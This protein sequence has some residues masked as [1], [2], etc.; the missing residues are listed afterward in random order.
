MDSTLLIHRAENEIK[1][2]GMIFTLSEK[3]ALQSETFSINEP[4]TYY[5]AVITHCYYSIFYGAKAFLLTRGMKVSAPEEH[6]K[7]YEAFKTFVDSGELDVALLRIYQE[8]VVQA[9]HLLGIFKQEKD[10]RGKYTYRTLPQANKDP[11]HESIVHATTFFKHM[12]AV[13]KK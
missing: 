5:S 12:Y 3:P 6:K 4:E 1:L 11:A 2:A 7:A 9:E 8:A 10:K 13:V